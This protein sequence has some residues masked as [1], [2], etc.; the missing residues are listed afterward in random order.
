MFSESVT[1]IGEYNAYFP[2]D[3][4]KNNNND[5]N[6]LFKHD[7]VIFNRFAC[8]VLYLSTIMYITN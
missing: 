8:G 7:F 2:Q 4:L 5:D 3:I 1:A 6:P